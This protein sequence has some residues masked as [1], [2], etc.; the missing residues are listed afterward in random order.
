MGFFGLF[1]SLI[2]GFLGFGGSFRSMP[3]NSTSSNDM[4]STLLISRNGTNLK[5]IVPRIRE[6][7]IRTNVRRASN[8][9][10]GMRGRISG[11]VCGSCL[12][13]AGAPANGPAPTSM[14][15]A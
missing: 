10:F 6:T 1:G 3:A 13:A 7:A 12:A 5:N 8:Y 2:G 15:V 9:L 11:V 14:R 4:V